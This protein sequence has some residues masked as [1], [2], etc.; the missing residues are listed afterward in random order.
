[1]IYDWEE[2][3]PVEDPRLRE[4]Y[5][6]WLIDECNCPIDDDTECDC[7]SFDEWVDWRNDEIVSQLNDI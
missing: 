6:N 1:M 2:G 3:P 5:L 7:L 4:Q